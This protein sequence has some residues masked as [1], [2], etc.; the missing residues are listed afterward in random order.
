MKKLLLTTAFAAL[1]AAPLL[2]QTATNPTPINPAR[3]ATRHPTKVRKT[4]APAASDL[5]AKRIRRFRRPHHPFRR[6]PNLRLKSLMVHQGLAQ[7]KV[8]WAIRQH[9]HHRLTNPDHIS[10]LAA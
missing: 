2:A 6:I 8:A 7:V 9:Q 3:G 4:F 10:D 5:A 1:L